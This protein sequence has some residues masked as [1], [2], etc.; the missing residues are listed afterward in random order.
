MKDFI[1]YLEAGAEATYYEMLQP[2]G[3]L[4]CKCGKIFNADTEGGY[5]LD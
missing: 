4:K 5:T 3:R 2:D 1:E